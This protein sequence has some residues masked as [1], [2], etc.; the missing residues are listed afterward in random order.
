MF[1]R[2]TTENIGTGS[3][4][5]R[6]QK[7]VN[8]IY[9][10]TN[11]SK[12]KSQTGNRVKNTGH[13]QYLTKS[14]DQ[15]N[16]LSA[17]PICV[18]EKFEIIDGQH[19][20][21]AACTLNLPIFYYIVPGLGINQT[22][23]L[24]SKLRNWG[25]ADFMNSF[26]NNG[27][28]NYLAYRLFH[29]ENKDIIDHNLTQVLLGGYRTYS[30][31]HGQLFKDGKFVVK[32]MAKAIDR[33]NKLRDL[34]QQLKVIRT[35]PQRRECMYALLMIMDDKTYNHSRMLQKLAI[36]PK[37]LLMVY[38]KRTDFVVELCNIYNYHSGREEK[39]T[40]IH[41]RLLMYEI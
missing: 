27:N 3:N 21:E 30:G 28:Q 16:L 39:K 24:N 20:F 38:N 33:V 36:H 15:E 1:N 8:K 4:D 26:A 23:R 37:E 18:N 17:A 14:I 6:R 40:S 13:V 12:F 34:Y 29:Q 2:T 5:T 31:T 19:R 22:Q 25:V 9:S 35:I 41:P 10:T 7:E 11:Y 32:D